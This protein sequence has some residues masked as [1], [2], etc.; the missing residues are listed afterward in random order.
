MSPYINGSDRFSN[1]SSD[2]VQK[3][4]QKANCLAPAKKADISVTPSL[5]NATHKVDDVF[6]QTITVSTLGSTAAQHVEVEITIPSTLTILEAR[7]D[8]GY[9]SAC[10]YG[11]GIVSCSA[12]TLA[13]NSN[14]VVAL[15]L[16][17]AQLG[18][19]AIQ[20]SVTSFIDTDLMNN[21]GSGSIVIEAQAALPAAHLLITTAASEPQQ[22]PPWW[23]L[24]NAND[25]FFI[26][27]TLS[28]SQQRLPLTR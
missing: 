26:L 17:S 18:T 19:H 24:L 21:A 12:A 11:A 15:S 23:W 8:G 16:Q 7:L 5:G 14:A 28:A 22:R 3:R 6:A 13:A 10:T 9:G 27:L 4:L 20:A 2:V 25:C 1:C